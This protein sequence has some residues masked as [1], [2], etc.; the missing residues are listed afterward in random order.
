MKQRRE[1]GRSRLPLLAPSVPLFS[2]NLFVQQLEKHRS[3]NTSPM[4]AVV[5]TSTVMHFLFAVPGARARDVLLPDRAHHV[6]PLSRPPSSLHRLPSLLANGSLADLGTITINLLALIELLL[7]RPSQVSRWYG[8]SFPSP[9]SSH[10]CRVLTASLF[11]F[12]T[13]FSLPGTNHI[14]V[15]FSYTHALS[16]DGCRAHP[17]G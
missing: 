13:A 17:P 11:A 8:F 9:A 16:H 10:P 1:E 5:K 4:H 7:N 3:E 2:P 6:L 15:Q 14:D 12:P